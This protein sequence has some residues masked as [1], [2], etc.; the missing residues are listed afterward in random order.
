MKGRRKV[1]NGKWHT[2]AVL[3]AR[4]RA[5]LKNRPEKQVQLL[6]IAAQRGR[7]LE[8]VGRLAG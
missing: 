4:A 7:E 8:P 6:E 3:E 5:L 2:Q 1:K